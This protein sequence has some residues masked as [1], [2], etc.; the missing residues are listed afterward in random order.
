MDGR[1]RRV[2][3]EKASDNAVMKS[4]LLAQSGARGARLL[5]L[6]VQYTTIDRQRIIFR[7]DGVVHN[8][9]EAVTGKND[10]ADLELD[11]AAP[12]HLY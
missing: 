5:R 9:F 12:A 7:R 11:A 3:H 1:L 2:C 10:R 6:V 4:A 8:R